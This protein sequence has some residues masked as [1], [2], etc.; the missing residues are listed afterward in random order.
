MLSDISLLNAVMRFEAV[1]FLL[2]L[3]L[4]F[5]GVWL[6]AKLISASQIEDFKAGLN[7]IIV[8][9]WLKLFSA[10]GSKFPKV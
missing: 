7:Q 1:K 10:L 3:D 2:T 8:K 9:A 4:T 6:L 5:L